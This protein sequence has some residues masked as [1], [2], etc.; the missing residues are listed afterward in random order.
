MGILII[1]IKELIRFI[2]LLFITSLIMFSI[3][4]F[5]PSADMLYSNNEGN[6]SW[7]KA[8]SNWLKDIVKLDLGKTSHGEPIL[9][10]I[11]LKAKNS[12]FL[13][14]LAL[15][16]SITLTLLFLIISSKIK[17][18]LWLYS[19]RSIFYTISVFPIFILGYFF[20]HI[21]HHK[22]VSPQTS[23]D[24]PSWVYYLIPSLI[25]GIGDGVLSEFIRHAQVEIDTIKNENYI[26]MAIAKGARLWHHLKNDFIIHMSKIISLHLVILISG[27]VIIEYIFCLPGIGSLAFNAA[28]NRDVRLLLGILIL[29]VVSVTVVNFIN[30]LIAITIDP[31]L[32]KG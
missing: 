6:N 7:I 3:V 9:K 22:L 24:E 31:R 10:E 2:F 25:L 15:T 12:A 21:S 20:L 27:T 13:I 4:Y 11:M 26:R 5:S 29:T 19:V 18:R 30:R 1:L 16:I 17:Q 8:Y 28:E 32:R 14:A 23:L